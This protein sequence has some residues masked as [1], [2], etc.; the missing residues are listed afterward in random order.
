MGTEKKKKKRKGK[1]NNSEI[2]IL[3]DPSKRKMFHFSSSPM[4]SC[5]CL[6]IFFGMN[7]K[8]RKQHCKNIL[9]EKHL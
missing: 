4:Y 3:R 2:I 9:R 7:L 1:E 6:F 8:K 5:V